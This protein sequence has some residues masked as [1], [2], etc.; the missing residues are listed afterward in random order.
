MQTSQILTEQTEQV[1]EALQWGY[2][3]ANVSEIMTP[4]LDAAGVKSL[5]E[6]GS[7][8]GELTEELLK[9]AEG[10][11][12]ASPRS[13]RCRR[14]S[15]RP[16]EAPPRTE[17]IEDTGVGALEGLE[18][19]PDAIVIDG[20]HNYYTLTRELDKIAEKAGD[21]PLPSSFPRRRLAPRAPRHLL[22]P[23]RVPEDERQPLGHNFTLAPGNPGG[24]SE[25]LPLRMAAAP[26][27]VA[28]RTAS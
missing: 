15:A 21:G 18:S 14:P 9:W 4:C 23:D 28:R 3:L 8:R 11:A 12:A 24:L 13:N 22:R 16:E 19:L 7:Y 2:S 17:L 25:G 26:T 5:L 27:K 1:T 10:P 6:I 20:D